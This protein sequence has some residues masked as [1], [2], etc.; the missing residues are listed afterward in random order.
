MSIYKI[1]FNQKFSAFEKHVL[2]HNYQKP[3]EYFKENADETCL[4]VQEKTDGLYMV[5][6]YKNKK[7]DVATHPWTKYSWLKQYSPW[8]DMTQDDWEKAVSEFI[9]L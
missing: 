5:V 2:M 9:R 1:T 8:C 7:G 4:L 3:Q 6:Y